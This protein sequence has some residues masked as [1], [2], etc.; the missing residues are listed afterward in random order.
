[1]KYF[2]AF[3]IVLIYIHT[4]NGVKYNSAKNGSRLYPYKRNNG[5]SF[6]LLKNVHEM[7]DQLI[8]YV[9]TTISS[10]NC[11]FNARVHCSPL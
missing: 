9:N 1:M 2:I 6:L 8:L 10:G 11:A 4:D 7:S 5:I 3:F